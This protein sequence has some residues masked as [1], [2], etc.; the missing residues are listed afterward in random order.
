[1]GR[2][3]VIRS[4]DSTQTETDGQAY[5]RKHRHNGTTHYSAFVKANGP[6][7]EHRNSDGERCNAE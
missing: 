2:K 6:N 7:Y 3:E 1:M 5:Q 4:F